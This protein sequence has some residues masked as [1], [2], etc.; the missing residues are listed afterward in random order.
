MQVVTENE[1]VR[2]ASNVW[3]PRV[4]KK[5][6]TGARREILS[7][8]LSTAQIEDTGPSGGKMSFDEILSK[9]QEYETGFAGRGLRLQKAQLEDTD[10]NGVDLAVKWSGDIGSY[11]GYWPQKQAAKLLK[12]GHNADALCYDGRPFFDAS[13]LVNPGDA[14]VGTFSNVFTG[15]ASGSYPGACVIDDSVAMDTA[16]TNLSKAVAYIRGIKMPNGEDPRFLKPVML[17][18][19]P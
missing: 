15:A 13:H 17:L 1:Y 2:L 9:T 11:M 19:P 8:L 12:N 10:G 16:L 3:W 6:P 14:G 7:W 4:M 5:R 18:A